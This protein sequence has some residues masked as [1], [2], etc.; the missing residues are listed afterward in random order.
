MGRLSNMLGVNEGQE[1]RFNNV[2]MLVQNEVLYYKADGIWSEVANTYFLYDLIKRADEITFLPPE[3][4][5]T[6]SQKN[7]IK[8]RIAEGYNWIAKNKKGDVYVY[9]NMPYEKEDGVFSASKE[10]EAVSQ[11]I[12]SA[13]ALNFIN[14]KESPVYLKDLIDD[15]DI[16]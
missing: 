11:M 10:K 15:L 12:D 13:V 14:Y 4:S 6:E 5:L 16:D 8:G 1:F 7:I 3:R 9:Q 2:I